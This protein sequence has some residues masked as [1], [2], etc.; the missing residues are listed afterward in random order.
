MPFKTKKAAS[1]QSFLGVRLRDSVVGR[2]F[3][4]LPRVHYTHPFQSR[5]GSLRFRS[6]IHKND[7]RC[8]LHSNLTQSKHIQ[9]RPCNIFPIDLLCRFVHFPAVNFRWIRWSI[10]SMY[11]LSM[12]SEIVIAQKSR[13]RAIGSFAEID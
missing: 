3:L 8:A 9:A 12:C 5:G 2:T 10:Q 1:E 4:A 13:S 11:V 6:P 7:Y